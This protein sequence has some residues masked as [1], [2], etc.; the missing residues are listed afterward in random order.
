MA[1]AGDDSITGGTGADL[2]YGGAGNDEYIFSGAF[3]ADVIQD[4]D[5][6]GSITIDGAAALH[7]GK[8]VDDNVWESIDGIYRYQLFRH[9]AV[10]DLTIGRGSKAEPNQMQGSIVIKGWT[11]TGFGLTLDT[12]A[13]VVP[14]G[15]KSYNGDQRGALVGIAPNQYYD[16]GATTWDEATGTLTNGVAEV[17]F[18]D[19][20]YASAVASDN[21]VIHGNGGNDALA[22]S[23]SKDEIFGDE[24]N[25]L[26]GGGAGIPSFLPQMEYGNTL[27]SHLIAHTANCVRA[28]ECRQI[29]IAEHLLPAQHKNTLRD[30]FKCQRWR[31]AAV[32]AHGVAL[33]DFSEGVLLAACLRVV[34]RVRSTT[35]T[36]QVWNALDQ[37]TLEPRGHTLVRRMIRFI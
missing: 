18:A 14:P 30:R 31:G 8:K 35:L 11:G 1:G 33:L 2:L 29:G 16:W 3:G 32:S 6:Q 25:D 17:N 24:G 26:I 15:L 12:A 9:G 27:V 36:S 22:G 21:T 13:P 5:G 23:A 10:N 37:P 20:I 28:V 34:R 4:S 19:V 7:G